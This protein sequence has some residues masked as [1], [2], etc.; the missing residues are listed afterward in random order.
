MLNKTTSE[1]AKANV[2]KLVTYLELIGEYGEWL[3]EKMHAFYNENW[4]WEFEV[5]SLGACLRP[6]NFFFPLIYFN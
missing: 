1:L 6:L 2:S 5:P 3:T 4:D